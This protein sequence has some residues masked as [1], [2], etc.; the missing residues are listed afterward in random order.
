MY[1]INIYN[2]FYYRGVIAS[3]DSAVSQGSTVV[4]P[5]KKILVWNIGKYMC[6]QSVMNDETALYAC[7]YKYFA[8]LFNTL[9]L[10]LKQMIILTTLCIHTKSLPEMFQ[11]CSYP[12]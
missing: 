1:I 4:S 3:H 10:F 2:Y 12:V 9:Y 7:V 8:I 11:T 6:Y 5:D